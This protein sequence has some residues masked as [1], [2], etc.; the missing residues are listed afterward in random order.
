[1]LGKAAGED[2]DVLA[3]DGVIKFKVLE[4]HK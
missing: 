3:P 4:I 2:V 1:L